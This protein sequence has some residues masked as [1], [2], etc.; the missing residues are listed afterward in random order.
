M[1]DDN[2]SSIMGMG[3]FTKAHEKISK[4]SKIWFYGNYIMYQNVEIIPAH[5]IDNLYSCR[6]KMFDFAWLQGFETT[7]SLRRSC[8]ETYY[9]YFDETTIVCRI[10]HFLSVLICQTRTSLSC[11][12]TLKWF[13]EIYIMRNMKRKFKNVHSRYL[14]VY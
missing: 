10:Y 12:M 13:P 1:S 7:C 11:K 6:K 2:Q 4:L 3:G 14:Q 8:Y 9:I 5:K